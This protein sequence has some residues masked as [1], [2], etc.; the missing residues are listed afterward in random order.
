MPVK[1]PDI[2]P[3][4]RLDYSRWTYGS[5]LSLSAPS[6]IV[7]PSS[8]AR[9][10]QNEPKAKIVFE[11]ARFKSSLIAHGPPVCATLL[12]HLPILFVT[13]YVRVI[14]LTSSSPARLRSIVMK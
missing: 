14:S 2:A 9:R 7:R 1:R 3:N 4:A 8:R 5:L 6:N 13:C 10:Q 11:T 12:K